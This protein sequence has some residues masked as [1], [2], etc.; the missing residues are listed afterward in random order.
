MKSVGR[1]IR[2]EVSNFSSGLNRFFKS[3][4]V[5]SKTRPAM[6][7]PRRSLSNPPETIKLNIAP[8]ISARLVAER[9]RNLN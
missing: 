1:A 3:F 2:P 5:Y 8:P 9:A 7:E 4:S 6:I